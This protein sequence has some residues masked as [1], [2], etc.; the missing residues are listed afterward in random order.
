MVVGAKGALTSNSSNRLSPNKV[1]LAATQRDVLR[2]RLR[3]WNWLSVL[4]HASQVHSD[5]SANQV[6]GLFECGAGSHA[7][8]QIRHVR[9]VAGLRLFEQNGISHFSPACFRILFC[10]FASRSIE[11]WPAIVTRP[12]LYETLGLTV[13]LRYL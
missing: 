7:S 10:V 13:A 12:F 1:R 9:T 5:G 3:F 6:S 4:Y 11:G 2:D 8:R